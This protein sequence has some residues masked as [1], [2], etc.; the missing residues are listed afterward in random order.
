MISKGSIN[1]IVRVRE[2]D[3]ETLTLESV[4]IV[5]EFPKVSH[6]YLLNIYPRREIDFCIVLSPL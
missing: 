6:D 3:S 2:L 5:N 1:Y 4:P